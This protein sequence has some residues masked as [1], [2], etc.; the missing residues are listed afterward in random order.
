MSNEEN[1]TEQQAE[2]QKQEK[3]RG[4]RGEIGKATAGLTIKQ[5]WHATGR[6]LSLKLFAGGLAKKGDQIAKDWFAHKKGSL[7]Q[8][9]SDLNIKAAMEARN[10]T[11]LAKRKKKEAG[12]A[13]KD[14]AA[15]TATSKK[16]SK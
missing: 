4:A 14:A 7:N 1:V 12:G 9:R 13:K 10:A 16:D 6:G 3:E 15:S 8:K 2:T 11:K 5:L